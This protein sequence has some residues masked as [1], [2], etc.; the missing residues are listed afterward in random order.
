MTSRYSRAAYAVEGT[1]F[2]APTTISNLII[3]ETSSV[4]FINPTPVWILEDLQ[5]REHHMLPFCAR[6]FVWTK[7]GKL[8]RTAACWFDFTALANITVTTNTLYLIPALFHEILKLEMEQQSTSAKTCHTQATSSA[9][10]VTNKLNWLM[11]CMSKA[12]LFLSVPL[13]Q[14]WLQKPARLKLMRD[15]GFKVLMSWLWVIW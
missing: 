12:S 11:S 8:I 1:A 15:A 9:C 10:I 4:T 5:N 2:P 6:R 7:T 14:L 3:I 13:I